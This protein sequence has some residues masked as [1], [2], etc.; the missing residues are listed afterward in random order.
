MSVDKFRFVSPG[1]QV[2]EV[3]RSGLEEQAPP[4][5][6]A[7][8][9]R[10]LYGPG[11]RAIKLNSTAELYGAFGAPNPGGESGDVWRD[12][13]LAAPTYGLYAAEAYLRNNG[14][15]TFVRLMGEASPDAT[16]TGVAGYTATE[17]VGLFVCNAVSSSGGGTGGFAGITASLGAVIYTTTGSCTVKLGSISRAQTFVN[18]DRILTV[19]DE[20]SEQG[21]TYTAVI[22]N[23]QGLSGSHLTATFNFD[24]DS[25]LYIR[26]V[27]NTN[28]Q[29]TNSSIYAAADKL[30]YW[31][32]E[33]YESSLQ[34][35]LIGS[36][37]GGAP[38]ALANANNYAFIFKNTLNGSSVDHADRASS[39]AVAK[40]GWCIA[41]DLAANTG[42]F[43]PS[44]M[45]QLFRFAGTDTRGD[46]DNGNIKI[47]IANIKSAVNPTVYGYGA[48]DV[49]VRKASDTDNSMELI[50]T[51]AQ[52]NLDP[53]SPDYIARRIGDKYLSWDSSTKSYDSYGA[54]DNVSNYIRVQMNDAVDNG[55]VNEALLPAGFIGPPRYIGQTVTAAAGAATLA[56]AAAFEGG[57]LTGSVGD[58]YSRSFLANFST[59]VDFPKLVL[60]KSG[61]A[62]VSTV[63]RAFYGVKT[64]GTFARRD[65]GYGDY[66][67]RLSNDLSDFYAPD[68]GNTEA[69]FVF[70]LDDISGSTTVPVY[71]SGSRAAGT[72]LRGTGSF[73]TLLNAGINKF[74]MPIVAGTTGFDIVEPEPFANRLTAGQT[75]ETS[76]EYYSLKKAI[77]VIRDPDVVEHNVCTVPGVSTTGITDYLISMAEER[78]DTLALIDI[79]DDYKPRYEL[80]SGQ[81]ATNRTALPNVTN[82]VAAMKTRGFNTSYGAAYYPAIQIRDRAKGVR[83]F[84]PATVA[85]MAAYGH[86]DKIAAPWFAPAGFNRGGLSDASSGITATGVSKQLRSQDRDDLYEVNVNPIA[87]FPQEGVVIFG[88]K[89]LQATP[90]ALD[91]VNVRR[92]LI[93]V[94]KEISRVANS[95]LFQPNVQ[96]TWNRFLAQAEPI[97]DDVRARFGLDSYRLILDANTTTPELVDRNI[98]YARV[99]LKPTRAIEFIAIDFEIFR[100]GASF[101]D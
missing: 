98:L 28:P 20:T 40:T 79:E 74:T 80:T 27:L 54:Y 64:Q 38:T 5:G 52:V 49:F 75:A 82:A 68:T 58:S 37:T 85:A 45:Q 34:D 41:Q 46:F 14:P 11:M 69:S 10:A 83:L 19:N 29:Y 39:A 1:V 57:T 44:T 13:S 55:S 9:G 93:F 86:T 99:L 18:T 8:I 26:K 30:H 16:A 22:Q 71:L 50:E 48:F 32:G 63:D 12:G 56:A 36:T 43:N 23:Y 87:Q 42:S 51:F 78:R 94:K 2:A 90:S 92:L 76:Y 65:P 60:R 70:T 72:S 73:S 95:I 100:S 96:D 6:P 3:D 25:D 33:T 67:V 21:L 77:D 7:V 24:P 59:T 97:L 62:G 47:S 4:I 84:V 91:R 15:V 31:L 101:D 17:A 35:T 88:Q 61:S 81:I 53:A 66:N 89:T